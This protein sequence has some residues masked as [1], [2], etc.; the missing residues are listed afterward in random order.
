VTDKWD[1]F[2]TPEERERRLAELKKQKEEEIRE[3]E[4][5]DEERR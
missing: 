4:K 5:R 2:E 1:N 3:K